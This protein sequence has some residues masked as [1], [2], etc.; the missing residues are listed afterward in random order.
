MQNNKI[1]NLL[2]FLVFVCHILNMELKLPIAL[3]HSSLGIDVLC[4]HD[5]MT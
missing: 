4:N 2:F 3:L 1:L 5:K